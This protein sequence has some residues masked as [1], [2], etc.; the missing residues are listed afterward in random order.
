[1]KKKDYLA[2]L[3]IFILLFLTIFALVGTDS[4]YGSVTDWVTQHYRIP[5]YFRNLFYQT[6][7]LFPDFAFNLGA[8]Q[9]IYYLSYY[10]LF[11]PII[12]LSYLFPFI[13][14]Q[15]YIIITTI[16]SLLVSVFLFYK[17]IRNY[18][19]LNLSFILTFLFAF[20][21]PLLFH[22]HRHIMF[23]N[24]MP[25][26]IM[27]LMAVD[28]YFKKKK[29]LFLIISVFLL[30]MT[31][32][33]FSV[34]GIFVICIY[35]VYKYIKEKDKINIKSSI[36]EFLKFVF[37]I[38]I[39]VLLSCILLLPTLYTIL[40]GRVSGNTTSLFS[41]L[42]PKVTLTD[43][44]YGGYAIGLTSVLILEIVNCICSKKRENIFLGIVMALILSFP[45]FMYVLN[46]GMYI[47][48]KVLIPFIPLALLVIA[49]IF[50]DIKLDKK[51]IIIYIL[52]SIFIA[53]MNIK[54]SACYLFIIDVILTLIGI[55]FLNKKKNKKVFIFI[56]LGLT[57]TCSI[58][59]NIKDT[60][61]KK[62]QDIDYSDVIEYID[63]SGSVYRTNNLYNNLNSINQVISN[64]YYTTSIYSSTSSANYKQFYNNDINNEF[65]YRSREILATTYNVLNNIYLGNKYV[66]APFYNE[67]GYNKV[68]DKD[69]KMYQNDNVFSI[70]YATPDIMSKREYD[71]LKYPYNI[72][73]LMHY[74]IVDD[75]IS[76][77]YENRISI[78][79]ISVTTMNSDVEVTKTEHGYHI[80]SKNNNSKLT[81]KIN[82]SSLLTDKILLLKFK[83]KNKAN[84]DRSIIINGIEN[85]VTKS[86]WKYHNQNYTFEYT[87]SNNPTEFE[88]VFS[89][90]EFEI[91][92]IS[93][94]VLDSSDI[95][96]IEK[97]KHDDYVISTK[98]T[99]GDII[100]G[101]INVKNDGYF[102]IS[103]PYDNG[104]N[105]YVD[106]N[107]VKYEQ[108]NNNFIGFKISKGKHTITLEYK[109]PWKLAGIIC[110]ALG[111]L[112]FAIVLI[113]E[114]R[115]NLLN[116]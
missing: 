39:S 97:D 9:N 90:G 65:K 36:V 92:D 23:M 42:I 56:I 8:G 44:L 91:E 70:G 33:F 3:C 109:S 15:N 101:N 6:H 110:S 87:F 112:L 21:A 50:S 43:T 10:G 103:I 116:K 79:N 68:I 34:S 57:F 51:V 102:S 107:K 52:V 63:N 59:S 77:V 55:Y 54:N 73:A 18:Y 81:L 26:L 108:V 5:E 1:M 115:K 2:L 12:L 28:Y 4:L 47:N 46:G 95:L 13:S 11:S 61:V 98:N 30:I 16:I 89:K 104:F 80:K 76:N 85:K 17:W 27:S 67:I 100:T 88:I 86:S 74:T 20:A 45:I 41:L 22:S 14:M 19:D 69:L 25:F 48:G 58:S 29:S 111:F 35:A 31:S 62:G 114:K 75:D 113:V 72:D 106:G 40:N 94:F 32:Y 93:T 78:A 64:S 82:D 83:I 49:S 84:I 37:P 66:I 99:K 53:F 38:F 105:I 24:Y 7:D 60:L 71:T 96:S